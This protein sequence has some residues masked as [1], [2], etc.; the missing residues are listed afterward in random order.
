MEELFEVATWCALGLQVKP[1]GL[2]DVG[3]YYDHL[4]AFLDHATAEGFVRDVHRRMMIVRQDPAE[5]LDALR[6]F[7]APPLPRW[8]RSET[9]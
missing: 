6:S 7:E 9:R 4:V 8:L 1:L 2:L 3:G 5:L